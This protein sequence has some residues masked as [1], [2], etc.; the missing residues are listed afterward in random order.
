MAKYVDIEPVV[1]R[2]TSVCVTDDSFGIGMQMG[3]NRAMEII[4]EARIVEVEP[5]VHAR[6]VD[7][8]DGEYRICSNCRTGIPTFIPVK[9]W[10]RC[11]V[12]G[13]HMDEEGLQKCPSCGKVPDIGYACG[14]YFIIGSGTDCPVCDGFD[15]M[16][17][18]EKVEIEAWNRRVND[19]LHCTV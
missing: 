8:P 15:E 12:C 19:G 17:S 11:L 3:I 14:E 13:A 16:H 18:S 1:K 6:W 5:V 10:L 2:L 7:R 9:H 4:G